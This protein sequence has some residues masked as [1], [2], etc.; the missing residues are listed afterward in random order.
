VS[1]LCLVPFTVV[2]QLG[3]LWPREYDKEKMSHVFCVYETLRRFSSIKSSWHSSA[4]IWNLPFSAQIPFSVPVKCWTAT[5]SFLV[6]LRG[7]MNQKIWKTLNAIATSVF[8]TLRI[9]YLLVA[10]SVCSLC[11]WF[12]FCWN[13]FCRNSDYLSRFLVFIYF[14]IRIYI[15]HIQAQTSF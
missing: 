7:L 13:C 15:N 2:S 3:S 8:Q 4:F 9:I 6:I 5:M 10:L 14:I 1:S 11:L 12:I